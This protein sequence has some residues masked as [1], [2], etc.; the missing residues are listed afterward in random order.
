MILKRFY[1]EKLAQASY[2][3]GCA[4]TGDA[5]VVDTRHAAEYAQAHVPGTINLPL[6]RSFTTWAGW[7]IPYDRDFYLLLDD[8]CTH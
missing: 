5:L 6:N 2:L 4:A 3:I 7:L 1:D 8:R